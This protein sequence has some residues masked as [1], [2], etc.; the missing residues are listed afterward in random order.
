MVFVGFSQALRIRRYRC[1]ACG[2]IIRLRPSG[3]YRRHQSPAI[4]IRQALSCRICSGR[5]PKGCVKN[6]ARHW[7]AA[8]RRNAR[9]MLPLHEQGDLMGV[10]DR[11]A[12]MGR[13]P[14]ARAI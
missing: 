1:P 11:L 9:A 6:R 13:V 7:L 10:F 3:Y 2:G 8:L 5:W 14:V 4:A 12:A